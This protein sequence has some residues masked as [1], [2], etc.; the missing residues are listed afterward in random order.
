[1]RAGGH[2][3]RLGVIAGGGGPDALL[4]L[5]PVE[6]RH[7]VKGSADLEGA[8]WLQQLELEVDLA[9]RIIP[10]EPDDRR[11]DGNRGDAG[12]GGPDISQRRR[13]PGECH[14]SSLNVMTEHAG[15][16]AG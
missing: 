2:R 14:G 4:D 15:S 7:C 9:W 12:L 6:R 13:G 8:D 3:D 5:R 16:V 10:V 11:A 1:E